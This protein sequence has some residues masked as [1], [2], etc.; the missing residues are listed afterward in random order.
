[1]MR[2]TNKKWGLCVVV[3]M[4]AW[5]LSACKDG[6]VEHVLSAAGDNR[7]ELEKV[8]RHYKGDGQ[9]YEAARFL[10]ANMPG[11][12]RYDSL[13]AEK[14]QPYYEGLR[15]LSEKHGWERTTEWREETNAYWDGV[16]PKALAA[17]G[18]ME[19]ETDISS[20]K[21]DWL[22]RE[23][24]LAFKAWQEN[25]YSRSVGFD[26][27]CRYV[28]PYRVHNGIC[29]DDTR[30]GFYRRHAGWFADGTADFRDRVDSL[31]YQYKQ[32]VHNDF[33]AASLP[34]VSF[35]VFQYL[36]KGLCDDRCRF[37][38]ALLSA[39]GMPVVQ[40]FVPFWGNR[41]GGHSWN[42]VV[43]GGEVYPFEAFWDED[44]WK[45]KRIY[46][47]ECFDLLWGEFRLPKVYRHTY[48][49]YVE[50]PLSDGKVGRSDIPSF[51]LNPFMKD[52]SSQ[53]FKT[54][55]V[56]ITLDGKLPEGER[57]CYLCVFGTKEWQPVQ[58]GKIGKGGKVVFE[59]MGRDVVYLPAYYRNGMFVPA[60]PAFLLNK[61]GECEVMKCSE[62]KSTVAVRT[63]TSYLFAEDIAGVKK[64]LEGCCVVGCN[65]RE[66]LQ[67]DTLFCMTDTMDAWHNDKV[68]AEPKKYRYVKVVAPADSIALC[69]ISFYE[70]G[71]PD[72]PVDGV[73]VWGD[74]EPLK[75]GEEIGMM[76]D[77]F[78]ATGC[79][80][81][82]RKGAKGENAVWFDLNEPRAISRI[83]YTP[84]TEV[85]WPEGKEVELC[86]WDGSWVSAGKQE[87]GNNCLFFDGLPEG[88]IYRAKVKGTNDRIFT[89]KGGISHWY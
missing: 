69:E 72:T 5:V 41:S 42:A 71:K 40:D 7:A 51:F 16:K 86:Y 80:G 84:Y 76:A 22:I 78:T 26:E 81:V 20:L 36:K 13:S 28:L 37:N 17:L 68:M 70:Q 67:G 33:A 35:G 74:I 63:Y 73:K 12:A 18:R 45:Y 75:P 87:G 21:A 30:S 19:A 64:W 11:H 31:L 15:K 38:V 52:V 2:M 62:G 61:K 83:A 34:L 25:A 39:L 55:D 60:A 4:A 44:R 46:N 85:Y 1:M 66:S 43:L 53:Y 56:E 10:V 88:T 3:V 77:R 14:L 59:D 50:G 8:L 89:S 6:K 65:D 58:W 29:A 24:D 9:K 23:I 57:Y 82:F 49:P 54:T 47:N 48:E 32:L 79:K 27:F